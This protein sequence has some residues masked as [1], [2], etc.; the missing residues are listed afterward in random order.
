[1]ATSLPAGSQTDVSVNGNTWPIVTPS[2]AGME[3][4][5]MFPAIGASGLYRH[6]LCIPAKFPFLAGRATYFARIGRRERI[7]SIGPRIRSRADERLFHGQPK[8]RRGRPDGHLFGD[9]RLRDYG[10]LIY[11]PA[12]LELIRQQS[13]IIAKLDPDVE[14]V[15]VSYQPDTLGPKPIS[16]AAHAGRSRGTCL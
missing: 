6:L 15:N 3:P 13:E 8:K 12:Y 10:Q 16:H 7:C 5:R 11:I 2:L 4:K 9:Y 1:M 14:I